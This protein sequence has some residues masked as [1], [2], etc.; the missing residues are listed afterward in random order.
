MTPKERPIL[1]SGAMVRAILE[2]RKTQTRRIIKPQPASVEYWFGGQPSDKHKGVCSLRDS[3]GQ[4]WTIECEK[5]KPYYGKPGDERLWVRETFLNNALQG[6]PPV[7][8]YRADSDEKP[9]DRKWK[10]SIFMPR[11][12]SRITL[13]ITSVRVER[14]K[15]I[16]EEDARAEG[17]IWEQTS[18]GAIFLAPGTKQSFNKKNMEWGSTPREAYRFL[19][20]SINGKGSWDKN[21]WVWVIEFKK[22]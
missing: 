5:F 2:G 21:P 18:E 4:G 15:D 8:F 13:E 17:I 14:L 12:A 3:N 6:Y 11:A 10:P 22:L 9:E 20:E 16:S 1:F 19:W 7:Y